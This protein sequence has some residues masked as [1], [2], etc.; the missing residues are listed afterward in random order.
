M[1]SLI[2]DG[3]KKQNLEYFSRNLEFG[4]EAMTSEFALR[5]WQIFRD[6]ALSGATARRWKELADL[7]GY[8]AQNP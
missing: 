4:K 7:C 8:A 6:R 2:V 1:D 3:S 5:T